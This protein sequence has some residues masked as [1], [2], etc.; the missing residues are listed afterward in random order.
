MKNMR[1]QL[2][3][4]LKQVHSKEHE[5][6]I[7]SLP[8]M[9]CARDSTSAFLWRYEILNKVLERNFATISISFIFLSSKEILACSG[10]SYILCIVESIYPLPPYIRL[11]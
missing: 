1:E 7:A 10:V 11:L 8:V 6:H 4:T 5:F 3:S 2:G 9:Q